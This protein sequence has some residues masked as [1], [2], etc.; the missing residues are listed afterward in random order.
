MAFEA[1]HPGS[2]PWMGRHDLPVSEIMGTPL[3][4]TTAIPYDNDGT[5]KCTPLWGYT[6]TL[7]MTNII[8]YNIDMSM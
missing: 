8:L 7:T 1:A 6:P 2:Q 3:I 4:W 5:E